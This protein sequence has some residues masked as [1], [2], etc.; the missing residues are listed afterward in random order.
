MSRQRPLI[1][2][3]CLIAA[4][5]A[6]RARATQACPADCALP[7]D[8]EVGINDF[9]ALL[10]QWGTIGSCDLD[11]AGV[12][13]NDFLLLL[14]NWGTCP[15][16]SNDGCL[17]TI[18][19]DRFDSPGTIEE[20]FDMWGASPSP[21][22]SQ[23]TGVEPNTF[24]DIWYCLQNSANDAKI[25]TLTGSVDLLA[26]ITAGCACP[27]GQ[28]LTC[29]RLINAGSATTFT[30]Q[31]GEAVCIRLIND[32]DLP[33]DQIAG[34][35]L[36]TNEPAGPPGVKCFD[37]PPNHAD[38]LFSDVDCDLCGVTPQRVIAEQL[39]LTTHEMIE[40][41]RF[42]GGYFPGDAGGGDPLPDNF[43]VKVR[44][45]DD[46]TGD[47]LPGTVIRKLL[48]GPATTR[49]ATGQSIFGVREFEYTINLEPNQDL[50][51]D[52][53]W[54]EIYNDTTNDP[55]NDDW[56]W[57][58]GVLDAVN[59]L[60]GSAFSTDLPNVPPEEWTVD[61]VNDLSLSITCKAPEPDVNFYADPA[62]FDDAVQQAGKLE[63]FT[64]DFLPNDLPADSVVLLDD[65]Q[66]INTH[67]DDPDDPWGASWP[68]AVDN[69]QFTSNTNPAGSLVPAG[70]DGLAFKTAGFLNLVNDMLGAN[71]LADSFDI[72]SG[73]PNPIIHTA[74]SM[75]LMSQTLAGSPVAVLFRV[76]VYDQQDQELGTIDIP[77]IDNEK[78]FLGVITKG[79]LPIG[80]IDIWD[81]LSDGATNGA[82]GISSITAYVPVCDD[83][84][85][86]GVDACNGDPTCHDCVTPTG[87][88]L[89]VQ[90]IPCLFAELCVDGECRSTDA[91]VE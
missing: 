81:M 60:P 54:V 32:L 27:P 91:R 16:P 75:N 46:S 84:S 59:G 45:N 42:W 19:I 30:M 33:N 40:E 57:E 86:G 73:A 82:E 41:L 50:Q 28:L 51:P 63:Q 1:T 52:F 79:D 38:D 61:P 18:T 68:P 88:C 87:D 3:L 65:P 64:W 66:D 34:S 23:C 15:P 90:G 85:Q 37:Q 58:A 78:V 17:G 49:T 80:R 62:A 12:G 69:I 26:E 47:D 71:T 77:A 29:G 13:I 76:T 5:G 55:T 25:V 48:V 22:A 70:I 35:L 43:T 74:M 11:G 9:L 56:F 44:L 21:D 39:V 10:G 8:K 24:K 2:C 67:G 4:A 7:A 31:A 36:L 20:Q 14:G 89:C 83:C 72:I 53:Y 6:I